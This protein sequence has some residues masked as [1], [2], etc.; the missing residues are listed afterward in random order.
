MAAGIIR[1]VATCV[2]HPVSLLQHP[3][4]QILCVIIPTLQ[5][6][7]LSL[8]EAVTRP[9]LQQGSGPGTVPP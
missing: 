3:L 6:S 2:P 8:E 7:R 1:C 9:S 4:K 5:V